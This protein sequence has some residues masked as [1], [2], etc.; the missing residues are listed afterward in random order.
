MKVHVTFISGVK[1]IAGDKSC[2]VETSGQ[3]SVTATDILDEL[4]RRYTDKGLKLLDRGRLK[5]GLFIYSRNR[6]GGL[7]LIRDPQT[8]IGDESELV[9]ATGMEG[10]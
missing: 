5:S 4:E 2:E 3:N 8:A 9:I 1:D 6:S 7:D 10:G